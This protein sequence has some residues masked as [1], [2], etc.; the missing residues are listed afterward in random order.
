[1]SNISD[2]VKTYYELSLKRKLY[3][4]AC[5]LHL[6]HTNTKLKFGIILMNTLSEFDKTDVLSKEKKNLVLDTY[7]WFK[8][9]INSQPN[10]FSDAL[11]EK[12]K[13]FESWADFVKFTDI[14]DENN[15]DSFLYIEDIFNKMAD[16]FRNH[17]A[18]VQ[19]SEERNELVELEKQLNQLIEPIN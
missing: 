17:P 7:E 10:K 11:Y 12:S 18:C 16:V 3:V 8:K 2:L 13:T 5:E 4:G 14:P 6:I 15:L 19:A 9:E 1:M